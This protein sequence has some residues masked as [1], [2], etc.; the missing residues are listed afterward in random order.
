MTIN[1]RLI[2]LSLSYMD[3]PS[4]LAFGNRFF[5][6]TSH[7][8]CPASSPRA[9]EPSVPWSCSISA[10][11]TSLGSHTVPQKMRLLSLVTLALKSLKTYESG[12]MATTRV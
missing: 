12:I 2:D 8:H 1:G 11:M 6:L 9:S 3:R 4:R 7:S 10:T 5:Y